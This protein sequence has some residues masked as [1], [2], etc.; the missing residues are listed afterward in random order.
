M[1]IAS[2]IKRGTI[3]LDSAG[4]FTL[5]SAV[6]G[7]RLVVYSVTIV[8]DAAISITF[9]SGSTSI[10]GAIPVAENGG[11]ADS[12][13]DGLFEVAAGEDF[14]VTLTG[15]C[16]AVGGYYSYRETD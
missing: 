15:T 10:T 6:S 14:D 16:P 5:Q 1:A 13:G 4:T 2:T 11:F 8:S 3:S 9:K 7:K 12:F